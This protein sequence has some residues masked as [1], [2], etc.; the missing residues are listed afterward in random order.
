MS[1][2]LYL[3]FP[4]CRYKCSYCDFYKELYDKNLEGQ[5]YDALL[6]ETEL[7][8]ARYA[9][10][11]REISSIF[12]GGGTPS[13]S[14]LTLMGEW[15]DLLR[16]QFDIGDDIEFSIECNP[17]SVTLEKLE[18]LKGFGVNRPV[19]GI[20]SFK[21]K[22]LSVLDRRHE[23]H[24]SQQAVYY[25]N[26]LGFKNFGV[27]LIF[28][29]P[30]QMERM[31]ATDLDEIISIGPPHISLYQL[32][33]EPG[34]KLAADVASGRL[35]LSDNDYNF[36]LYKG[37]CDQMAEAGYERYEVS[38]FARPGFECRHNIG[39]WD[40]SDY[41]GL[42]PSAHSFMQGRRYANH[43]DLQGYI[44]ALEAGELPQIEDDTGDEARV[45]EAIMLGLRTS[46]GIN[47][48]RF[49][50]RFGV[51][52]E[53]RLNRKQYDLLIGS[54]HLIPDK[55]SLRLSDDGLCLADEI[56]QRLLK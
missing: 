10:S 25:A 53:N 24:H 52:L 49:N 31:L 34:T 48:E 9:D 8:A 30:G 12:I 36:A 50:E 21:P 44:K 35:R 2:G 39:Y 1:F 40:G 22:L 28:G 27:D 5:F 45:T 26:V 51:P 29:L 18:I 56:T 19:F 46:W 4:F 43:S 16:S 23:P 3:H 47:R 6:R 14:N 33:V 13:I 32:T 55:G 42:G 37:G 17:E 7:L 41:L 15:L 54:G 38:S 20:Q 11:D